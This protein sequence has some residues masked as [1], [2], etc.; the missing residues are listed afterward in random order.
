MAQLAAG[1]D[2]GCGAAIH[3]ARRLFNENNCEAL[4]LIDAKNAFN[5]LNR[6]VAIRNLEKTCHP[7]YTLVTSM[8]RDPSRLYSDGDFIMSNEGTTQGDTLAMPIF[9]V[10]S[11]PIIKKTETDG[12]TQIWIADDAT[13]AGSLIGLRNRW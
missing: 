9:A 4:L 11:V 7:F 12:V 6:G 10:S 2:G 5:E 1:Q 3:S 8:Y 13:G